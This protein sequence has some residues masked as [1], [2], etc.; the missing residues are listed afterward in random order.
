MEDQK[1]T[2]HDDD[3]PFKKSNLRLTEDN[4]RR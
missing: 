3:V 2:E 1:K 4:L